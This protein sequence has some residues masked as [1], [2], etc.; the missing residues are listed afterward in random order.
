MKLC[1]QELEKCTKLEEEISN[2]LAPVLFNGVVGSTKVITWN[3]RRNMV[4]DMY[5]YVMAKDLYPAKIII[6]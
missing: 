3:S 5:I 4:W 6:C 2:H 1:C